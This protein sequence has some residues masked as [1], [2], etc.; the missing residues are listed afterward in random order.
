MTED[1]K[2]LDEVMYVADELIVG[3]GI[4]VEVYAGALREVTRLR[5]FEQSVGENSEFV[6][7]PR[8]V[9]QQLMD[10]VK[11]QNELYLEEKLVTKELKS[12]IAYWE[13]KG[14]LRG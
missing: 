9:V 2:A 14:R 5:E 4:N 6:R 10:E 11:R 3:Q 7:L 8:N 12:E 1:S 13:R